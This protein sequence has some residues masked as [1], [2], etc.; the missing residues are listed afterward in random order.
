[1]AAPEAHLQP[2]RGRQFAPAREHGRL[3]QSGLTDHEQRIRPALGHRID[4]PRDGL[5]DAVAL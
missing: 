3:A 4:Q 5:V 2:G 1:M